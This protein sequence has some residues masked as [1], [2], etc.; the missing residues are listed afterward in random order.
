MSALMS[1]NYAFYVLFLLLVDVGL[2]FRL[3]HTPGFGREERWIIGLDVAAALTALT[4][5]LCVGMGADAGQFG[6]FVFNFSFDLTSGCIAYFFFCYCGVRLGARIINDRRLFALFSIPIVALVVALVASWWTGWVFSIEPDGTYVR[7]PLFVIFVFV[8]ANGY[9][10][11]SIIMAVVSYMRERTPVRRRALAE[12]VTYVIPLIVGTILQFFFSSVP[13]SNMGMTLTML[14]IFIDNQ[15]RLLERKILEAEAANAAKTDFLSRMSHD[16]RTPINGIVGMIAI[17]REN[18]EDRP[19]VEDCLA[20]VDS[21]AHQLLTL[22]SDVLDMSKIENEGLDLAPEPF[23]LIEMLNDVRELNQ[24]A[25]I[26]RGVTTRSIYE[27]T[28]EHR[29]LV[30]STLHVRSVLNNLVSNGIKYTDAGGTVTGVAREVSLE[31]ARAIRGLRLP[32]GDVAVIEFIVSDT[33][34]GMSREFAR[35][36]FEPFSQEDTSGRTTYQGSGLGLAIVKRIVDAMGGKVSVSTKLGVGSTFKVV[37]PFQIASEE[38]V[39]RAL[40]AKEAVGAG[41]FATSGEE[42]EGSGAGLRARSGAEGMRVLLVEDNELNREI[43][44]YVLEDAGAEVVC[45]ADGLEALERFEE[46]DLNAFDV[47]LMDVMMPRMGGL[48]ATRCIRA[49]EREDARKV[50]I[51]GM[52]ANAFSDDIAAAREAG[53]DDYAVKPLRRATILNALAGARN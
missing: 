31:E 53:M 2:V 35:R 25:A 39:R 46:S 24:S 4:D 38:Q 32:E 6:N 20:K 45:A 1:S 49:L 27:G 16:V 47:V 7:G 10:I 11:G 41:A 13:T 12:C 22:V 44:Q 3:S 42:G 15:E 26:D 37:L 14:L 43:A 23:D 5:A 9:T 30:G 18:I 17:A 36:V 28:I 50:R 52:S 19:R 21:A 29:W 33:G 51:V 48:E 40:A 8:L 34:I